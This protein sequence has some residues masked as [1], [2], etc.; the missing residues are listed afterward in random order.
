[1]MIYGRDGAARCGKLADS[2]QRGGRGRVSAPL[3]LF[4]TTTPALQRRGCVQRR[5]HV[6]HFDPNFSIKSMSINF[7]SL[8]ATI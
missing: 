3:P 5:L 8:R 4:G 2:R 6:L 1:M 7:Y